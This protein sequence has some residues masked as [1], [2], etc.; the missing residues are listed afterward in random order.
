MLPSQFVDFLEQILMLLELLIITMGCKNEIYK[1]WAHKCDCQ[2]FIQ[3]L[4]LQIRIV[5]IFMIF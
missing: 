4:N 5:R 3:I 2:Y 1:F